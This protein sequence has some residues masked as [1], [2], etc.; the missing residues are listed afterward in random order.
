MILTARRPNAVPHVKERRV[1]TGVSITQT[2]YTRL[3]AVAGR[4]G[5][6]MSEIGRRAVL[7]YLERLEQELAEQS[8][9]R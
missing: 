2:E 7:P 1:Q 6:S 4:L 9:G 8:G 5:I 3:A